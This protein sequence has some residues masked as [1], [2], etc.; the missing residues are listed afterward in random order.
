MFHSK[1]C[2]GG[3][4]TYLLVMDIDKVGERGTYS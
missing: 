2:G 1:R 3:E 4:K